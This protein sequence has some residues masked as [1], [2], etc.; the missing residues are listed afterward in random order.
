MDQL[1]DA[2]LMAADYMR[3]VDVDKELAMVKADRPLVNYIWINNQKTE[4][5]SEHPVCAMNLGNIKRAVDN[6]NLYQTADFRIW[7]DKKLMDEYSQFCIESFIEEN[8]RFG[9]IEVHDLQDIPD[10]A[11]DEYFVPV[12]P[13]ARKMRSAAFPGLDEVQRSLAD[14]FSSRS[15]PHNVYSRADYARIL[16]LDHCMK[17]FPDRRRL[18]YSDIDCEDVRLRDVLPKLRRYGVAIHDLGAD[19]V[20]HGYIGIAANKPSIRE[21]FNSLKAD[22]CVAAHHDQLGFKMFDAFLGTLGMPNRTWHDVIGVRQ[23][24]PSMYTEPATISYKPAGDFNAWIQNRGAANGA[25]SI[26]AQVPGVS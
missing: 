4:T 26:P 10:Y 19:C 15:A 2:I 24:L 3:T 17:I 6:A 9:N 22:T 5:D 7:I 18:I 16:V 21:T 25:S 13:V 1:V 20:S 11:G 14:D 23:L 8:S 12:K